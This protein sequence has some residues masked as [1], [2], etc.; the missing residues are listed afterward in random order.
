MP[1]P[2]ITPVST[3]VITDTG[4]KGLLKW[5]QQ[6]MPDFYK[7]LSPQLIAKAKGGTIAGLGC[8]PQL[9]AI[10]GGSFSGRAGMGTVG[11][12]SYVTYSALPGLPTASDASTLSDVDNPGFSDL[13]IAPSSTSTNAVSAASSGNTSSALATT[14]SSIAGAVAS[15]T[16][17]AAQISANN[18]LLQTNLARAQQG[19]P[20]LTST[21]SASGLTT[22]SSPNTLL[23]LGIAAIAILAM[24]G[25]KSSNTP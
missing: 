11:Y 18:T 3:G 22:L 20:P 4:T 19:L 1:T 9:K 21:V 23:I 10:Y 12:S 5:I 14:I 2:D 8:N 24:G 7:V 13:S 25:S 6:A 17:A 16:V 15:G